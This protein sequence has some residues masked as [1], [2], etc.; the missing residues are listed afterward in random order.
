MHKSREKVYSN[1]N[2]QKSK[3]S[4]SQA[5][6]Q[7]KNIILQLTVETSNDRFR[8]TQKALLIHILI[9]YI[10]VGVSVNNFVNIK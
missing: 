10:A 6:R 2:S 3:F 9:M 8:M 5:S 4:A 1:I 7:R